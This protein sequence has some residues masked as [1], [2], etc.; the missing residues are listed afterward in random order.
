MLGSAR[1]N[2]HLSNFHLQREF[3]TYIGFVTDKQFAFKNQALKAENSNKFPVHTEIFSQIAV[4]NTVGP[5]L[6]SQP[7]DFENWPLNRGRPF[8]RGKI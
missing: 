6:S 8:N 5:L 3:P 7:R 2:V 4:H 1:C